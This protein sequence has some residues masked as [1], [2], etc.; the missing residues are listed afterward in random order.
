MPRLPLCAGWAIRL[1]PW[2]TEWRRVYCV[3][4][5]GQ[6]WKW[7][8]RKGCVQGYPLVGLPWT[9][10]ELENMV[11]LNETKMNS[12]KHK[13]NQ[14]FL[15]YLLLLVFNCFTVRKSIS[16]FLTPIYHYLFLNINKKWKIKIATYISCRVFVS[17]PTVDITKPKAFLHKVKITATLL[18]IHAMKCNKIS[19]NIK[20]IIL[21]WHNCVSGI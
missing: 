21:C 15:I 20:L 3:E 16:R 13:F 1:Q 4:P 9:T 5:R 8:D 11:F 19:R 6:D 10:L 14:N 12:L 17:I 7:P 2:G 18:L